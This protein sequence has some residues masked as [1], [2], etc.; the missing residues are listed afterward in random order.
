M[1]ASAGDDDNIRLYDPATGNLI[2]TLK[3]HDNG[4]LCLAFSPDGNWLTCIGQLRPKTIRLWDLKT[5]NVYT[6]K[7]H[8]GWVNAVAFS[9]VKGDKER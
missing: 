7:G 6:L 9:P 1:L 5:E 2:K 4:V 8:A 3:G